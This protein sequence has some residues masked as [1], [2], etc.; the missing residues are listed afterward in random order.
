MKS[1]E[2]DHVDSRKDAIKRTH[3]R[4]CQWLIDNPTFRRWQ[5][6]QGL[7]DHHGFLW[8]RGK[9]GTGKSTL[10]KFLYER[11]KSASNGDDP[12]HLTASFFFHARG[13]TLEKSVAG[14]YRSLLLQLLKRFDDLQGVLDSV[15]SGQ[16]KCPSVEVLKR[17][18]EES[19]R[20]LGQRRLTCF[21]DALDEGDEQQITDMVRYFEDLAEQAIQHRIRLRICFSSRHYPYIDLRHGLRLILEDQ[22]GHSDDLTSYI[23]SHLRLKCPVPVAN[24]PDQLLE[25]SCGVF[26]W[27]VLV[28]DILNKE[29][30]RGGFAIMKR[31]K[32]I[33]VD[34]KDLFADMVAKDQEDMYGLRLCIMWIL[35][36]KR[37]LTLLEF[38]HAMWSGMTAAGLA[39][40][41]PPNA[42]SLDFDDGARFMVTSSS[43]GL[44]EVTTSFNPVVQFIHESVRD[45]LIKDQGLGDIWPDFGEARGHESLA[46]FCSH[47]IDK[48]GPRVSSRWDIIKSYPL[49]DYSTTYVLDHAEAAAESLPQSD[50]LSSFPT[51]QWIM[52]DA[53]VGK[54]HVY[55][56]SKGT[57][58]LY[59]LTSRAMPNLIRLR[60]NQ[61]LDSEGLGVEEFRYP[62]FV[63]VATR[64]PGA[65]AAL[66]DASS[67]DLGELA[68]FWASDG[69]EEFEA[70]HY[71]TQTP[72]TWAAMSGFLRLSVL[73]IRR[74]A[75]MKE[76]DDDGIT[77]LGAAIH[78]R[79]EPLIRLLL[80]D[81]ETAEKVSSE[82]DLL[83][84]TSRHDGIVM[85]I[86]KMVESGPWG[87][88]DPMFSPTVLKEP[89]VTMA[90]VDSGAALNRRDSSGNTPLSMAVVHGYED[91][92]RVLIQDG[93]DPSSR[94][95]DGR[96]PLSLAIFHGYQGIAKALIEAGADLNS[97][98][99]DR[100]A[101]LHIAVRNTHKH[102]VSWLVEQGADTN[103][104]DI[105]G[106][107]PLHFAVESGEEGTIRL[108]LD[109]GA[110][111]NSESYD[112]QTP[113]SLAMAHHSNALAMVRVL[114]EAGAHVDRRGT[115][116]RT[117][118][119][120]AVMRGDEP[121]VK[122]EDTSDWTPL[123]E[124][125][126]AYHPDDDVV[127]WLI[128]SG[129]DTT[130]TMRRRTTPLHPSSRHSHKVAEILIKH[131][132][133]VNARDDNGMTPLHLAA[134]RYMEAEPCTGPLQDDGP[135]GEANVT[136][137]ARFGADVNARDVNGVTPLHLA[138]EAGEERVV[139]ALI[140][141]GGD[142]KSR[143]KLGRIP[144]DMAARSVAY[145]LQ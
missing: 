41:E 55:D 30:Y 42:L 14:M 1:L 96:T 99:I 117:P 20:T 28:V 31:L 123:H 56:F 67:S 4:T 131:G 68:R 121:T 45:F 66:L 8:I 124:A 17:L 136:L 120:F 114:V 83:V 133:Q 91:T 15:S 80:S 119:H 84:H 22:L 16:E 25:R 47:Y 137:L 135:T 129:A 51:K 21:I 57:R 35:F 97:L 24:L 79:K 134:Q 122:V 126:T 60:L 73:L 132:A 52:L 27:V 115:D 69:L 18:L 2:F 3:A 100:Q 128:R 62:L 74:G 113:L 82:E 48:I 86:M 138:A 36:S 33:P 46:R 10:M 70:S 23:R 112:G 116:G 50:F 65:V 19:I 101:P 144:R 93:A 103:L 44:A 139:K 88:V 81:S 89:E 98:D 95:L 145:L 63:A 49:L 53:L 102:I 105:E 12:E 6:S 72:L 108:L 54:S 77:P 75:D 59:I 29:S 109:A 85:R 107:T 40:D 92:T 76:C 130:A 61:S 38:Y 43:K 140:A 58:L 90:L 34:L 125:D 37:P 26:L 141:H 142:V 94:V 110:H 11:T 5:G 143:D 87:Y 13:H 78:G 32:E 9:P 71:K 39:E 106:Y 64:N 111:V 104:Q 127:K 118:L 7:S